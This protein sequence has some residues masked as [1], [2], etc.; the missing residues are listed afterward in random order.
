MERKSKI[1][2]EGEVKKLCQ[3]EICHRFA[4]FVALCDTEDTD[5]KR[6]SKKIRGNIEL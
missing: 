3:F 4:A 5:V 2:N 6:A 1:I